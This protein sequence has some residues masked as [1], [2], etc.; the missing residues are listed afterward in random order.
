MK[1]NI[2]NKKT[3]N[4]DDLHYSDEELNSIVLGGKPLTKE[5]ELIRRKIACYMFEHYFNDGE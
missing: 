2:E 1:S 5:A 4:V 3:I